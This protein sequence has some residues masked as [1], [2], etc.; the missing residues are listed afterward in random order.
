MITARMFGTSSSFP[1]D[2]RKDLPVV[3][4]TRAR[5]RAIDVERAS[6]I[7]SHG[8]QPIPVVASRQILQ[9]ASG[10]RSR[11][12]DAIALVYPGGLAQSVLS[13]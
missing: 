11:F 9:I 4:L 10:S 3:R 5:N 7:S 1:G 6:V 2:V 8:Q 13:T 12:F